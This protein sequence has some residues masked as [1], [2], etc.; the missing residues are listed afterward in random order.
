[1]QH[2]RRAAAPIAANANQRTALT[3]TEP[4]VTSDLPAVLPIR[5]EEVELVMGILG[6]IIDDVLRHEEN[7]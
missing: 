3:T 7:G 5:R 4:R 6:G 2:R 1:V